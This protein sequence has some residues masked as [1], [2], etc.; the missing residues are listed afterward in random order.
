MINC[1]ECPYRLAL[2]RMFDVHVWKEDC[3]KY[4]TEYC[5]KHNMKEKN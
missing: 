2:A 4:Q 3:D 1:K 5:L